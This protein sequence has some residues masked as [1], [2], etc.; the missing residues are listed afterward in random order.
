MR[1]TANTYFPGINN[2]YADIVPGYAT[3]RSITAV[4]SEAS[5][6]NPACFV[7]PP[8]RRVFGRCARLPLATSKPGR[9]D[10]ES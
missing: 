4:R 2:V 9:G 10:S 6:F 8:F 5:Y 7:N 1:I 3:S